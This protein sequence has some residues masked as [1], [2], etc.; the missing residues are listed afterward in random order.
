MDKKLY[1]ITDKSN[2]FEVV[3]FTTA[4]EIRKFGDFLDEI[5][6]GSSI[7]F[8]EI[9]ST[10]SCLYEAYANYL[11]NDGYKDICKKEINML[12]GVHTFLNMG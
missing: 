11:I 3:L 8:E 10:E 9:A 12:K 2:D 4:E 7:V 6:S 1:R 5:L